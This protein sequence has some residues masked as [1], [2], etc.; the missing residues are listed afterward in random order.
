LVD[1]SQDFYK[2]PVAGTPT[3]RDFVED[4][5]GSYNIG[6]AFYE[7]SKSETVQ[8]SKQ[9]AVLDSTTDRVYLGSNARSLIGLPIYGECKVKPATGDN[10]KYKIFVQSTSVNRKLMP[11][12]LLL[13]K[14][15]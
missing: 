12:T 7:L 2:I 3:I 9:I 1:V 6:K 5:F 14:R 4:H 15:W 10:A 8:Q 13:Y 11:N